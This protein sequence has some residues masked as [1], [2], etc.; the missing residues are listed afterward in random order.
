[1][2]LRQD[3][4]LSEEQ[5]DFITAA[6]NA[7]DK[8][9]ARRDI[10][11]QVA[12]NF[13]AQRQIN[14]STTGGANLN[15]VM[16]SFETLQNYVLATSDASAELFSTEVLAGVQDLLRMLPTRDFESVALPFQ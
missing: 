3:L 5:K 7:E 10:L 16:G 14:A 6:F 8:Q 2:P 12:Q 15:K 9:S 1:M 13:V 11:A 4:L